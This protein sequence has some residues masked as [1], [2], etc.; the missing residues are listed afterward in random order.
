MDL[1]SLGRHYNLI[2]I[3]SGMYAFR[4]RRLHVTQESFDL[5]IAKALEKHREGKTYCGSR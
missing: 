4:E 5:A 3:S 2:T 1:L